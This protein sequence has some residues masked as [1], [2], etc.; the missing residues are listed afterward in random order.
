MKKNF[1]ALLFFSALFLTNVHL[2]LAQSISFGKVT[3]EELKE[4][5]Y[6]KDSSAS[7]A[8]LHDF[9]ETVFR[10]LD[11]YGFRIETTKTVRIKVYKKA[12]SDWGN[13]S[14]P[15]YRE[16]F[17]RAE[18]IRDI[19]GYVY[20]LK[21]DMIRTDELDKKTVYEEEVSEKWR[22]MKFALPN[23]KEGTVLEYRYTVVS[24]FF[25]KLDDWKFQQELPVKW[26]EYK[27]TVPAFYEYM[28]LRQGY[29][30][31]A[32]EDA[33]LLKDKLQLG[34]Y[35]Y[36]NMRF[37]WAVKDIPAYRDEPY[38]T[39]REDYIGKVMFQLS[40]VNYPGRH[41]KDYMNTW[42]QLVED[43]MKLT[44]FGKN[45][46][47][48]DTK[49]VVSTLTAGLSSEKDKA[50]AIYQHILQHFAWNN[51]YSLYPSV[52][53]KDLLKDKE[54]NCTDLNLLLLNML[55][56]A[57]ITANPVLLSTRNHGKITTKFPLIDQFNYT[58][59]FATIDG[60]GVL[61]D[62][63]D[64]DLPFGMLREAC[65]NDYGLVAEE[66]MN[67]EKWI[68]VSQQGMYFSDAYI[69]LSYDEN[70]GVFVA[71]AKQSYRNYSAIEAR[72][73]CRENAEELS[74]F[75]PI[76]D[77]KILNLEDKDKPLSISFKAAYPV[78]ALGDMVYIDPFLM[79]EEENP[80]NTPERYFPVDF[81]VRSVRRNHFSLMI[82]KGYQLDEWPENVE[83]TLEDAVSF[84]TITQRNESNFQIVSTLQV[85]K[86]SIPVEQYKALRTLYTDM[87]SKQME[88][89]VLKK[90]ETE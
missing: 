72:K 90:I 39:T 77:L 86:T 46:K 8:V 31:L 17:S 47:K 9:S 42:P 75:Q 37:H 18:I 38:M 35:T 69:N 1:L 43:L 51:T 58:I 79:I 71:E 82:P 70:K 74:H 59:V 66:D 76:E 23:V 57:G 22:R 81:G 44:D 6:E 87:I 30:D 80:F 32:I 2:S 36:N 62:A 7:A 15:L 19:K 73:I 89:V 55:H 5:F 41:V 24:P 20:N 61:L 85:S 26:S 28:I 29:F 12:G 67:E 88:K 64:P 25:F 27:L 50:V 40:K 52:S 84:V 13:V 56:K 10:Y 63:T 68:D 65:M 3:Y 11:N 78:E 34:A 4:T 45:I 49:E 53:L 33:K 54:G 60:Q 21:T 83:L 48:N 14:I 16:D